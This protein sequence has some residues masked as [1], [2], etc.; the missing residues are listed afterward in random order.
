MIITYNFQ[1]FS[2]LLEYT[3]GRATV[4]LHNSST[5]QPGSFFPSV[6]YYEIE[7]ILIYYSSAPARVWTCPEVRPNQLTTEDG[8]DNAAVDDMQ[9]VSETQLNPEEEL[10]YG[11]DNLIG[12]DD[13]DMLGAE[14]GEG[15]YGDT[16]DLGFGDL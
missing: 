13:E 9:G 10:D 5:D 3:A 14:D 6:S 1:D 15:A 4:W 11:Y 16:E 7:Y 2:D 8:Q 12:D